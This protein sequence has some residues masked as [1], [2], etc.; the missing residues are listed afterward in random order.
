MTSTGGTFFMKKAVSE[1]TTTQDP[2]KSYFGMMRPPDEE[3]T[4]YPE[5]IA[6]DCPEELHGQCSNAI[7]INPT[8]IL[9]GLGA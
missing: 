8:S 6:K 2:A 4:V 9:E 5:L 3:H 1:L 7:G